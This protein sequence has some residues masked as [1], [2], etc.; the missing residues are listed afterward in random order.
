MTNDEFRM[1]KEIRNPNDEGRTCGRTG[2]GSTFGL[3]HSFDIRHSDFVIV[4]F[5]NDLRFAFRQLLKNPCF[6]VEAAQK[7]APRSVQLHALS[8]HN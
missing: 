6:T 4:Q 2:I 1:T 8:S 7:L 5:M 3:C